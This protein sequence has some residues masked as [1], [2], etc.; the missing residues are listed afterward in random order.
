MPNEL[1]KAYEP[2]AIEARWAEYW[3]R[4]KLFHVE[5]P[6]RQTSSLSESS[7]SESSATESSVALSTQGGGRG[8]PPYTNRRETD[9][10]SRRVGSE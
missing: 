7:L 8:R 3:V 5:T 10:T 6:A 2:A 4:E 9:R 1:P